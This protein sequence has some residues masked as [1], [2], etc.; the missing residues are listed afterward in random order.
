MSVIFSVYRDRMPVFKDLILEFAKH[1]QVILCMNSKKKDY[2]KKDLEDLVNS[3]VII[4]YPYDN[5]CFRALHTIS[6]PFYKKMRYSAMQ[7]ILSYIYIA[8]YF[9]QYKYLQKII[10]RHNAKVFFTQDD[11]LALYG[12]GFRV[13]AKKLDIPIVLPYLYMTG[14]YLDSMY[15]NPKYWVK[16]NLCRYQNKVF[17]KFQ[18]SEYRNIFYKEHSYFVAFVLEAQYKFHKVLSKNPWFNGCGL[19]DIVAIDNHYTYKRF[20]KVKE[21]NM[22]KIR[23]IGSMSDDKIFNS[24]E[25]KEKIKQNFVQEYNIDTSKKTLIYSVPCYFEHGFLKTHEEVRVFIKK[26]VQNVREVFNANIILSLHPRMKLDEYVFLDKE[27]DCVIPNE[28]LSEYVSIADIFVADFSSTVYWATLCGIKSL[29][30]C[31]GSFSIDYFEDFESIL[32]AKDFENFK[33]K[34]KYLLENDI[35]FSNDWKLLS[36]DEVFDG[37]TTQRYIKLAKNLSK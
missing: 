1:Y 16:S 5:L 20:E 17:E 29:I 36:R 22:D 4:Y 21:M 31:A 14:H 30:I 37:K 6:L 13:A 15:K 7:I 35:S 10:K 25:N 12:V 19:S 2:K 28:S 32:F 9:A 33:E 23:I 3:G 34:L 11:L 27:L 26:L 8:F 24:Y 18:K